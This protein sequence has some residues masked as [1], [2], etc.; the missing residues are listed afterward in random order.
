MYVEAYVLLN[1]WLFVDALLVVAIAVDDVIYD[2]R[3]LYIF[4]IN[5]FIE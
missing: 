1:V 2:L 3:K 4:R 5:R